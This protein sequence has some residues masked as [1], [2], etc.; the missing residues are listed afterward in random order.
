VSTEYRL[1]LYSDE[2]R[3]H[4]LGRKQKK[5]EASLLHA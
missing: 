1:K 2:T 5:C 4:Y 3:W